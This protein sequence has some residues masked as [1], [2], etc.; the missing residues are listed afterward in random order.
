METATKALIQKEKRIV[1][2]SEY[3]KRKR[4]NVMA[5]PGMRIA[6]GEIITVRSKECVFNK[7]LP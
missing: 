5:R 2:E 4:D 7:I 6:E 1:P 3:S